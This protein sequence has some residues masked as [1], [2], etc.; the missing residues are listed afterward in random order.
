MGQKLGRIEGLVVFLA[1]II[2]IWLKKLICVVFGI[3]MFK[4]IKIKTLRYLFF[5]M[6]IFSH[7][8]NL[9]LIFFN[10]VRRMRKIVL[11]YDS[12]T[13]LLTVFSFICFAGRNL[14]TF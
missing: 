5:C 6:L 2:G 12:K 7:N 3:T 11:N 13:D 10:F 9:V 1:E 4:L 14:S 8:L